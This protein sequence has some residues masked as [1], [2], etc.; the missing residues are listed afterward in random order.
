MENNGVFL[1]GPMGAGKTTVGKKLSGLLCMKF[2]DSDHL[3]ESKHNTTVANI[4][5]FHGEAYFREQEQS[6]LHELT[7]RKN[8]ILAT[9]GGCILRESTRT[10]LSRN[11]I[12]CYLRVSAQQQIQRTLFTGHR[13]MLPAN[14]S[15]HLNFFQKMHLERSSLYESIAHL[16]IDTDCFDV[17]T[18]AR[19]LC[20][21]IKEYN[22]NH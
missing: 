22:E 12:V 4:F 13:P 17:D 21:S 9:G 16:S 18:I 7:Q 6:L 1:V 14:V 15:E 2:I 3:L 11:G 8:T 19:M 10:I 20:N 5:N